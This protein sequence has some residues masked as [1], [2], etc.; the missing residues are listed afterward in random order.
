MILLSIHPEYVEKILKGEK[1]FEFRRK[2][3]SRFSDDQRIAIYSTSPVCRVVAYV[4][5]GDV[6]SGKPSTVWRR[7]S[8]MAGLSKAKF[9]SYFCGREVACAIPIECVHRFNKP[10]TLRQ[11]GYTSGAPQSFSYLTPKQITKIVAATRKMVSK[12]VG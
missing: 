3:P 5:A 6:I 11:A 9:D 1:I 2:I 8:K 4:D 7:T 10:I 12:N